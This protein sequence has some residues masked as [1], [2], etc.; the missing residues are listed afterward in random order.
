MYDER[1]KHWII[2][3]VMNNQAGTDIFKYSFNQTYEW[4]WNS[5]HNIFYTYLCMNTLNYIYKY[6]HSFFYVER[7]K[8]NTKTFECL[9][10]ANS[11]KISR[12][13]LWK[14]WKTL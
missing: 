13:I 5:N 6:T 2:T 8:I 4:F 12:K 9:S 7:W 10:E 3:H 1:N 14:G 11:M